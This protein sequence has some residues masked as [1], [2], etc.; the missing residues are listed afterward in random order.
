[1]DENKT[2]IKDY[3][4]TQKWSIDDL[5]QTEW[6]KHYAFDHYRLGKQKNEKGWCCDCNGA[7]INAYGDIYFTTFDKDTIITKPYVKIARNPDKTYNF[8]F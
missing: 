3:I 4:K 5:K 7:T 1:M 8:I 2:T 6:V